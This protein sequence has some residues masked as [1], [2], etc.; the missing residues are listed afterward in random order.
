MGGMMSGDG[1]IKSFKIR[2]GR[3]RAAPP[4]AVWGRHPLLVRPFVILMGL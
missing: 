2:N 1:L 4:G 3:I